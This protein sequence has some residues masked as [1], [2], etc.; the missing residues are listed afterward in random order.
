MTRQRVWIGIAL[1]LA[2]GRIP[3]V[4]LRLVASVAIIFGPVMV[5]P[6]LLNL[7]DRRTSRLRLSVSELLALTELRGRIAIRVRCAAFSPGSAVSVDVLACTPHE[8]W[9]IFTRV[10]SHL[11]PC[12]RLAVHGTIGQRFTGQLALETVTRRLPSR[13]PR[14]SLVT[15]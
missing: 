12:V 1:S 9:D 7:C 8:V 11:P 4:F 2:R 15:G 6:I 3:V 14:A 5:W 10:A 13:R